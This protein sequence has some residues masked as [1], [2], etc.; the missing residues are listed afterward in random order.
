MTARTF[1]RKGAGGGAA[2]SRRAAFVAAERA[3]A[4]RAAETE[5]FPVPVR[6]VLARENVEAAAAAAPARK[7]RPAGPRSLS[8]AYG[9]WLVLG[10]AGAHRLYLGRTLSGAIQALLCTGC[11]AAVAMQYYEAFAGLAA[12]WLWMFLDGF[13]LKKMHAQATAPAETPA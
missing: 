3:S 6:P 1:G 13:Q 4:D 12:C 11:L 10:T 5:V 9:L 7:P 8:L 2:Q